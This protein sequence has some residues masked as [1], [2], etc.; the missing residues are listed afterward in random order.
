MLCHHT[1]A[2][3]CH[4]LPLASPKC[5]NDGEEES[6]ALNSPENFSQKPHYIHDEMIDASPGLHPNDMHDSED[7]VSVIPNT[8]NY[9]KSKMKRR[10]WKQDPK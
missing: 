4:H 3:A 9:L 1:H 8:K 2:P 7:A 10:M 5:S 6:G